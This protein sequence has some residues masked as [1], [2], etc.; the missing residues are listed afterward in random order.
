VLVPISVIPF[1]PFMR[2]PGDVAE[3]AR[4]IAR[5]LNRWRSI[6]A[7][8]LFASMTQVRDEITIEGSDDGTTW[9][10]YAFR[11]KP[12][13]VDRAPAFVA[14]HQ[15]RVDFQLWFLLL[16]GGSTEPYFQTLLA[17]LLTAPDAVAALF[18]TDPF[19]GVPPRALRLAFYRYRFTDLAT[20]RADGTWWQRELL[21]HSRVIRREDL[22]TVSRP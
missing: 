21:G 8:H 2:V 12:G 19:P 1:F 3:A 9:K 7:Y 16:H 13:P 15:P 18:A 6:N 5:E 14:P 10:E 4:P 20:R 17:R 22:T 11:W